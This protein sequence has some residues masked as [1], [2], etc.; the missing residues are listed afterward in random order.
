MKRLLLLG[1]LIAGLG[2][3]TAIAHI[4]SPTVFFEGQAGPYPVHVVIRPPLAVP[5][6]AE[7]SV[8]VST[9]GVQRV[10]V[11]PVRWDAGRKGA[12]PPDEARPVT[13]EPDL[14][15]AELWLMDRGAYSVFVEVQGR[16]GKGEAIVPVN[17]LATERL[18]MPP[19]FGGVLLLLGVV[20]FFA[21]ATIAGAA[22]GESVLSPG[23]EPG[24]NRRIGAWI[25]RAGMALLV[26]GLV[27]LGKGW[28]DKVDRRHR[29]NR[30][31]RVT[32]MESSVT[33][34]GAHHLLKL[35]IDDPQWRTQD[36]RSLVPDHGK[37]MH[38]FLM[39]EPEMEAFAHLHPIRR[40][41]RTFE[42]V[43]PSLPPG[44]YRAFG[45]VTHESGFSQTLVA[46]VTN[47][48]PE[49]GQGEGQP[50]SLLDL[51]DSWLA[52]ISV[53]KAGGLILTNQLPGGVQMLWERPPELIAG[54]E[55]SLRFRMLRA[56]GQ[57]APLEAYM[58]MMAHAIVCHEDGSVFTHL[59]PLGTISMASQQLFAR[60]EN[61]GNPNQKPGETF[62]GPQGNEVSFP[63]EFPKPGRYRVWMQ[64][65][66]L[67][68]IM[69][70][71]FD[72]VVKPA[73]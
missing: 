65:R 16:A 49:A 7:V 66:Y 36:R 67:G 55:L 63:Y 71:C 54:R 18:P 60:R 14:Y 34:Q 20:L 69:T 39:R 51:D 68:T 9:N 50:P 2:V 47:P 29:T 11:L 53:P 13:G 19:W 43:L 38:L 31:F 40:D 23:E 61:I 3:R 41:S 44:R 46:T 35:T 59:H 5:G 12:P 27:C 4:G 6:R 15:S 62:C 52:G 33:N 73:P 42:T 26:A 58:G 70:G 22:V 24:R 1:A 28:W 56:D 32:Q 72:A 30:L 8:R 48:E 64:T 17:S 45:D 10:T 57:P 25:A 21:L 37:L